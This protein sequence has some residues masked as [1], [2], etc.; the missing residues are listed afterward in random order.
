MRTYG[1]PEYQE[2]TKRKT[3][4]NLQKR[5]IVTAIEQGRLTIR[6]AKIAY[7]IKSEKLIRD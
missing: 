6:G 1:S 7:N 5:T 4:T 3:Y 2:Q